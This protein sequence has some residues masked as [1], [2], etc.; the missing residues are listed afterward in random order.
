MTGS[1]RDKLRHFYEVMRPD[2]GATILD[3]GVADKEFSPY[4]NYLEKNYPHPEKITALSVFP[5]AEFA[6][7]YPA[8]RPVTYPGGR[9][10][11]ADG[12]FDVAY[13]NAVLEHVGNRDSQ[14]EFLMELHRVG[15]RFYFT[16]PAKEFPVELHTYFPLVHWFP[17]KCFDYAARKFGKSWGADGYMRLLTRK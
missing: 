7:R 1:R 13:S 4:D 5:L 8:I 14:V 12:Q 10:P 11:F 17:E 2:A 15:R 3:V 9:F 16:T 6:A